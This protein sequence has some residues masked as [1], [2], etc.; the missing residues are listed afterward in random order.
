[1]YRLTNV[2]FEDL[3]DK[4]WSMGAATARELFFHDLP[5]EMA[6]WA[7]QLLRPQ[8]YGVFEEPSPLRSWPDVASAYILCRQDRVLDPEWSRSTAR[9][10]LGV[11]ALELDGGHSPFLGRPAELASALETAAGV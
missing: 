3:G 7:Q 6:S 9:D 10:R 1:T 2:E 11:T 4:V 8:S 5:D